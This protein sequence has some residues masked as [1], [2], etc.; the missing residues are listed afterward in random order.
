MLS[1]FHY[2]FL[3]AVREFVDVDVAVNAVGVV[4]IPGSNQPAGG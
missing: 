3:V 1:P 2:F 4:V